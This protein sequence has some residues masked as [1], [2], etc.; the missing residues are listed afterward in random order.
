MMLRL[1][2]FRSLRRVRVCVLLT[3][4][5]SASASSGTHVVG[6]LD[7]ALKSVDQD[8]VETA[9]RYLASPELQGRD[10]GRGLELAARYVSDRF[11]SAG[12]APVPDSAAAWGRVSDSDPPE[13]AKADN[14][15]LWVRPYW[16]KNGGK[17]VFQQPDPESCA[18]VL[19]SGGE[20]TKFELGKDFIPIEGCE[21]DIRGDL[22]FA[23]FGIISKRDRYND[24]KDVR[25]AGK[26]VLILDGEPRHRKSFEG[27]NISKAASLWEKLKTLGDER[28]GGV[29][30]VRRPTEVDPKSKNKIKAP[31]D[32]SG[33][34]LFF[35][36][37]RAFWQGEDNDRRH[38]GLP[39][40]LEITP[41]CADVILGTD[42]LA[43]AKRIDK[44]ARPVKEKVKDRKV[45]VSSGTKSERLM[46]PNVT[47]WIPGSDLAEEVVVIGA[48]FDHI[49]V[50][51]RGRIGH[52][53]DDNASGTAALCEIAEALAGTKP[54][55]SIL[56]AGFSAEEDG[57][58][59]SD[60]LCA[61]LPVASSRIVAM[62]NLDMIGRGPTTDVVVLGVDQNPGMADVLKRAKRLGRTGVKSIVEC[63]D[64]GLFQRSDHYSFHK[65]G[66]PTIFLFEN[67]PLSKNKDY[68][69]WRDLPEQ[70]DMKKIVYTARLAICTAWILANDDERLPSP[71]K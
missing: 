67:Y 68:H 4:L 12:L 10:F 53:A 44:S 65:I 42:V 33:V 22:V 23:G 38:N 29:L 56:L 16:G 3:T 24:L 71:E 18:L 6:E 43:L 64:R 9:V 19:E 13:W 34:R 45:S 1:A 28:A 37:S 35:R 55:R 21:G 17:E 46:L 39:P 47:A 49:G 52:G 14:G 60:R 15:G 69:T 5:V 51:P 70:V 66:I 40:A 8:D 11:A 50:G 32:E 36:E 61:D 63:N 30:V 25:V 26:I 31:A 2:L 62:V 59:G 54:R 48:H 41:E 57:L 27:K 20:S 58:V 7:A